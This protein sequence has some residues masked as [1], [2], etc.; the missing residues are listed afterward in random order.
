[1]FFSLK[2]NLNIYQLFSKYA[3]MFEVVPGEAL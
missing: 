1:M 3:D 2:T